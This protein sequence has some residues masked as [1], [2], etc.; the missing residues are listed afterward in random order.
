MGE[1]KLKKCAHCG[2]FQPEINMGINGAQ[3]KCPYCGIQTEYIKDEDDD[4]E[5]MRLTEFGEE[6]YIR[7]RRPKALEMVIE[8]WNRRAGE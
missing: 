7:H 8:I 5:F 1:I 2:Y 4:M 6:A 3:I